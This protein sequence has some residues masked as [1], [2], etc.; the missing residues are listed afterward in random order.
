MIWIYIKSQSLLAQVC[1][2]A[3]IYRLLVSTLRKVYSNWVSWFT[4]FREL[5]G[6]DVQ[7]EHSW[8]SVQVPHTEWIIVSNIEV[9]FY[10]SAGRSN[11]RHLYF[12]SIS[13]HTV[14]VSKDSN[15]AMGIADIDRE[16]PEFSAFANSCNMRL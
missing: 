12:S 13:H 6:I 14:L 8:K 5:L 4:Y 11:A 10:W 2:A 3:H 15:V 9:R 1:W 16:M 7:S